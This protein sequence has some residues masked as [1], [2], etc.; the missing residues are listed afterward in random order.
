MLISVM[1]VERMKCWAENKIAGA[2]CGD[3]Y[4]SGDTLAQQNG[5]EIRGD[6]VPFDLKGH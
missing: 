6:M 2:S 3:D 4:D 1:N 5:P